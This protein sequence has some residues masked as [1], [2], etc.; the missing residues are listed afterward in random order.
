MKKNCPVNIILLIRK[1]IENRS[2]DIHA[3]LE[4]SSIELLREDGNIRGLLLYNYC[5]KYIYD[6]NIIMQII[7]CYIN[8]IN[9]FL[10][11]LSNQEE[12]ENEFK[13]DYAFVLIEGIIEFL[14]TENKEVFLKIYTDLESELVSLIEWIDDSDF[15]IIAFILYH[16]YKHFTRS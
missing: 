16:I 8:N 12:E 5:I 15:S 1:L 9:L 3:L 6:S 7:Q 13:R 10:S 11:K 2:F 14:K 4:Y